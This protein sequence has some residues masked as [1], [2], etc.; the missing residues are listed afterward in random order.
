MFKL[1]FP[2]SLL[3]SWEIS[4]IKSNKRIKYMPLPPH[5]RWHFQPEI[6]F[7]YRNVNVFFFI[8]PQNMNTRVGTYQWWTSPI[9][10]TR[11]MTF[12][13]PR[14]TTDRTGESPGNGLGDG[15]ITGVAVAGL[16][17]ERG[18]ILLSP[19]MY[20]WDQ[21]GQSCSAL[22]T[23]IT[24]YSMSTELSFHIWFI[25]SSRECFCVCSSNRLWKSR[26]IMTH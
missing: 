15:I 17:C 24:H 12:H 20:P 5:L 6:Y 25:P 11:L 4:K 16:Y 18:W 26:F 22:P 2:F 13:S 23:K 14:Y 10:W 7:I 19:G 9:V 21:L 1:K 8:V 3:K